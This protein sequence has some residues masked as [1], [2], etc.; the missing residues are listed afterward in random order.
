MVIPVL[1]KETRYIHID[2]SDGKIIR[3]LQSKEGDVVPI[4]SRSDIG[5]FLFSSGSNLTSAWLNGGRDFCRGEQTNEYNFLPMLPY[6]C[7]IGW[8]AQTIE[9]NPK[10]GLGVNT[11]EELNNAIVENKS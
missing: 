3:I 2:Q 11:Q 7:S 4:P 8:T 5:L 1:M 10:D 6:L 9:A